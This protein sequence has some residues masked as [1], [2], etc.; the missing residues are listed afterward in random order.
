[1]ARLTCGVLALHHQRELYDRCML[2]A[3]V[4]LREGASANRQTRHRPLV[5]LSSIHYLPSIH[6][7]TRQR[8]S[9]FYSIA[10]RPWLIIPIHN[11]HSAGDNPGALRSHAST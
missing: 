6:L 4:F 9:F 3:E 1:M 2:S 11:V 5:S 8:C 10:G 7:Y